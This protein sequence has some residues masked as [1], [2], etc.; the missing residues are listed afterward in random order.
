MRSA[1]KIGVISYLLLFPGFFFY[2]FMVARNIISPFLGGFF[3]VISVLAFFPLVISYHVNN[4]LKINGASILFYFISSWNLLIST[5]NY[6]NGNPRGWHENIFIWSVSGVLFNAVCYLIAVNLNAMKY[7]KYILVSFVLMVGI[8]VLNIGDLGIFYV[9]Q[10]AG[11]VADY[12]ATYQGFARSLLF[13]GLILIS[14]YWQS[15]LIFYVVLLFALIGLFFNGARTEFVLF[16]I[17]VMVC[18][19]I[20]AFKTYK[21]LLDIA[22]LGMV[23]VLFVYLYDY[24]PESRMS[25]IFELGTSTSNEERIRLMDYGLNSIYKNLLFGDYGSY[26]ELG[27]VGSYPHNIIS[28]WVNLGIIGFGSYV[29]LFVMLW[30]GVIRGVRNNNALPEFMTYL[31]FLIFMS[32]ALI[33]SKDYSFMGIGFVV[34]LHSRYRGQ[35]NCLKSGC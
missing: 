20:Y 21:A 18:V 30:M 31:I 23:G 16:A 9:K 13:T 5:L 24:I 1:E 22:F 26:V 25:Q 12:V 3:G 28:S 15:V 14:V 19:A 34:G 2:H 11:D 6:F 7:S 27:G 10:E 32:M 8:V 33:S 4:G 35:V 29:V 17:S